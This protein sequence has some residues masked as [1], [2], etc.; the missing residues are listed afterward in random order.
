MTI[1]EEQLFDITVAKVQQTI[2][3]IE[4][5]KNLQN[6]YTIT[7]SKIDKEISKLLHVV[8]YIDLT[9]EQICYIGKELSALYKQRRI[10]KQSLPV[11]HMFI[12]SVTNKN[13][14]I[15]TVIEVSKK[16][17]KKRADDYTE[18]SKKQFNE[19]F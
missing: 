15:D 8:E 3:N 11:L 16:R 2:D 17:F 1:T 9:E 18:L 7:L 14:N 4:E 19:L 6:Q 12:D 5:I 10:V 13:A